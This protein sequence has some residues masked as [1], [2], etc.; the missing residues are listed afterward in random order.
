MKHPILPVEAD[1]NGTLRFKQ[2]AIVRYLLDSGPFDLNHLAQKD[3]PQEDYEQFAQLIGYS[4]SG[5]G[6][7]SYVRDETYEAAARMQADGLS[8]SEARNAYLSE[9]LEELKQGM[10]EPIA[11]LFGLHPDDLGS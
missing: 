11:R 6:D 5:F 4:L 10:R 8:E 2:N 3:F 1:A 9:T 7:L